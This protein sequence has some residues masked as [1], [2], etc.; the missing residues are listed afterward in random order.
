MPSADIR[1]PE[2]LA[3]YLAARGEIGTDYFACLPSIKSARYLLY[4]RLGAYEISDE[5]GHFATWLASAR[6][7]TFSYALAR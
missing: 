6:G 3:R 7:P 1:Q 2:L 4:V 5:S